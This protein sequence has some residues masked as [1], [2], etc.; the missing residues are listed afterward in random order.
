M[1][2]AITWPGPNLEENPRPLQEAMA[3]Q[4]GSYRSNP[5]APLP[6]A[7]DNQRIRILEGLAKSR[8]RASHANSYHTE[9]IGLLLIFLHSQARD[10]LSTSPALPRVGGID[11]NSEEGILSCFVAHCMQRRE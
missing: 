8:E 4:P 11:T 3:D 10:S 6:P 5:N 7:L 1:T 2:T 9:K